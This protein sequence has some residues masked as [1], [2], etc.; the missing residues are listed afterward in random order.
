MADKS[1]CT[2][3]DCGKPIFRRGL[4][5]GHYSR[6]RKYGDPTFVPERSDGPATRYFNEVVLNYDGD[7]C[8]IWP[9]S[10]NQ[11]GQAQ[12]R[13][14]GKCRQAARVLCEQ[15]HGPAPSVKHDAA[16]SCGRGDDGC[17]TKSHLR[18]AT[19]KENEADKLLHGTRPMGEKVAKSKLTEQDVREIRALEGT[20]TLK[21]I[22]K[23]YGVGFQQVSNI[24]RRK[25][26][27]WLE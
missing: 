4:C 8:L 27:S 1:V 13:V 16:H 12:L 25:N 18:W 20:M 7:D 5:G 17:V 26:W 11:R 22:A 24:I 3:E 6:K 23:L 19:R 15:T 10:R 9:F 21:G 14:A 2:I